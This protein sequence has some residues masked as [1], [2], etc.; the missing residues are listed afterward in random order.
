MYKGFIFFGLINVH[1]EPFVI[2]YNC[3]MGDPETEV[4]MPRLENDLLE[5]LV[6][7]ENGTLAGIEIKTDNRSCS[8]VMA[9]SGGYP[10]HYQ[11]GIP[12]QFNTYKSHGSLIF[13]AGTAQKG[14][15]IT[16]NGGRVLAVSSFGDTIAEAVQQSLSVL[17]Q[18]DY[19]GKY[20]RKD[21]GYEFA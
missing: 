19:E 9:V 10:G 11:K 16:T 14:E 20:Y 1:D 13:H 17:E 7:I 15:E 3:R 6:A 4:V 12:I 5:L 21:I 18:I 8:T 2:E